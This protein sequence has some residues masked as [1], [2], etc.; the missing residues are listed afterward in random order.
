MVDDIKKKR[1]ERLADQGFQYLNEERYEEALEI[2]MQLEKL[3]YTAAFDIGAQA[4]CGLGDMD[5]AI[6]TLKRG[7]EIE[8]NCW[9]NLQLLGNYLSD[10]GEYEEAGSKYIEAL[11]CEGVW[12]DSI[13][14]NQAI[15]ANR[16][17]HYDK[18]LTSLELINDVEFQL[19]IAEITVTAYKGKGLINEA[20][21]LA[22]KTIEEWKDDEANGDTVGRLAASLGRMWIAQGKSIT[23]VREW[24]VNSLEYDEANSMLLALI[25]DI[26]N[27]YS[28]SAQY[29][30]LFVH[31]MIPFTHP[32]YS[33]A[34][35]YFITYHV[36]AD[37]KDEALSF[38]GEFEYEDLRMNLT[39][40]ES[41]IM[42]PRPDSPKGVYWYSDRAFYESDE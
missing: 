10:F 19:P 41:E 37:N 21:E 28:D 15:L 36:V 22:E 6:E 2:S 1:T 8:P 3:R 12:E 25:R 9:P 35:G 16:T 26:D 40:E 39:I 4:Y 11:K 17:G 32:S 23:E 5:K 14:L 42:E 27:K 18:A 30:R 38:V 31:C 33:D 20:I 34:I 29:F 13:R 24:A 7:V